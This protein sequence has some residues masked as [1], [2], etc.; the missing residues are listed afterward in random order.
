V[1]FVENSAIFYDLNGQMVVGVGGAIFNEAFLNGAS[2]PT[3]ANVQFQNNWADSA[4]GA[5]FNKVGSGGILT[6]ALTNV[7]LAGNYAGE[8]GGAI[9][10]S[11]EQEPWDTGTIDITIQNSI[12]WNNEDSSGIGTAESSIYHAD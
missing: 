7:T 2:N 4:G 10:N 9:Y 6:P 12:V 3:L 11:L 5:M 8:N 1:I